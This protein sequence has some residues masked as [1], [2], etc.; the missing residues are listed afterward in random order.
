ML[1]EDLGLAREENKALANLN[2]SIQEEVDRLTLR[3]FK[4]TAFRVET[5]KKN[6]KATAKSRRARRLKVSFDL[7]Q[8]PPE[9][10]GLRPIYLVISDEQATP[11]K[12]DNPIKAQVAVNGQP[13]DL[14]AAESKEV[15]IA[16][17][18]RLSFTHDLAERLKSGYYRIAVYTD[19][20]LLGASSLR[21]R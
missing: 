18:Q 15:N 14:I 13:T 20:G 3:D 16:Q 8:V 6:N 5:E 4:A 11:I 7:T 1:E 9:Y 10:Q 17:N 12:L 2:K 21:L 19:I